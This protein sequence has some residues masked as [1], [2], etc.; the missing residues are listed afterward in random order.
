MSESLWILQEKMEI[1]LKRLLCFVETNKWSLEK[2]LLIMKEMKK[3]KCMFVRVSPCVG[4]C[5]C[6]QG[7]HAAVTPPR[8][9]A[10]NCTMQPNWSPGRAATAA[11]SSNFQS[12]FCF[13]ITLIYLMCACWYVLEGVHAGVIGQLWELILSVSCRN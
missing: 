7:P 9:E 11:N 4:M 1:C 6:L 10:V 12:L 3:L 8:V 13:L 5:K 2:H